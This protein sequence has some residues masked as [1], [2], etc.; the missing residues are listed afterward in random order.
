MQSS[1]F[2]PGLLNFRVRK[3]FLQPP[4]EGH[5]VLE[6]QSRDA[7]SIEADD[8]GQLVT[9][10]L[11][12]TW[13]GRLLDHHGDE[14]LCDG[15]L[16]LLDGGGR[17]Q[18][19]VVAKA[20]TCSQVVCRGGQH[21]QAACPTTNLRQA[22]FTGDVDGQAYRLQLLQALQALPSLQQPGAGQLVVADL[23]CSSR[24]RYPFLL[25]EYVRR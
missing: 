20:E 21:L 9:H 19:W 10:Q 12:C 25:T 11:P 18:Y 5:F 3:S 2:F 15:Y 8:M 13:V 7:A 14:G 22:L 17:E 6:R 16:L 1:H 24:R 23:R 4:A